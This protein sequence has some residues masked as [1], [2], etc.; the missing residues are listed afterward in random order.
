MLPVYVAGS[1]EPS[2]A[3]AALA[4]MFDAL[5]RPALSEYESWLAAG[6]DPEHATEC[7]DFERRRA[8]LMLAIYGE[9]A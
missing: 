9:A 6:N 2:D 5:P 8:G 4:S 7:R 3:A 1:P